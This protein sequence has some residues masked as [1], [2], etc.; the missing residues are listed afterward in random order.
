[1][2]GLV[3]LLDVDNTLLDNDRAKADLG[4]QVA[5]LMGADSVERWWECY[6]QVRR[7]TDT[8]DYPRTLT[9]FRAAYP[10]ASRFAHL[11]DYVLGL[12]YAQYLYPGALDTLAHLRALGTP[13]IV[14][15]GDAVYQAAK[16]A[17]AGLASAVDDRVLIF[18]HK[19]AHLLSIAG[20]FPAER[21]VLIDDKPR[22]LAA[23]K[24]ILGERLVTLHVAQGHYAE[25]TERA[26]YPAPDLMVPT[27][28]D[29][30]GLGAADFRGVG[31]P[32]R[33]AC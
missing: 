15:D 13:A 7:E 28:A 17:R 23:A 21:Y 14:S 11:A 24:G 5:A 31:G 1:M 8:V 4:Q 9:Q 12:P 33:A 32:P 19:E 26:S 27:I 30:Q 10:D 18:H 16:I 20:C 25:A 22:I 3:F 6:E 29:V 2:D